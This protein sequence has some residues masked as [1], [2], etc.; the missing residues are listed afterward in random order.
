MKKSLL[1]LSMIAMLTSCGI[2][3]DDNSN[4]NKSDTSV[5]ETDDKKTEEQKT[6]EIE[7][8]SGTYSNPVMVS[9]SS[10]T[11]FNSSCRSFRC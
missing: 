2:K 5:V 3:T 11:V 10:G 6:E 4:E 9:T 7:Y 8:V 1:L